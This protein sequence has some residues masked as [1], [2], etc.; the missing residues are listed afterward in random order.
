MVTI[1]LIMPSTIDTP[2]LC[3]NCACFEALPAVY[4]ACFT[5]ALVK[6]AYP[7]NYVT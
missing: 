3:M 2:M 7:F 1:G 6:L 4:M 5:E